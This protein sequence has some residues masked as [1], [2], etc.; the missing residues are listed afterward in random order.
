[1]TILSQSMTFLWHFCY[2][3]WRSVPCC[4]IF[5]V[6]RDI[7]WHFLDNLWHFCD[8]LWH[9]C[10]ILWHLKKC[11]PLFSAYWPSWG[12]AHWLE[13]YRTL[14]TCEPFS[15]DEKLKQKC[16]TAGCIT[17]TGRTLSKLFWGHVMSED[18]VIRIRAFK[19]WVSE[20]GMEKLQLMSKRVMPRDSAC[21]HYTQH[22]AGRWNHD[23]IFSGK[24]QNEIFYLRL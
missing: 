5:S 16:V 24:I 10:D 1:M 18:E 17:A 8:V 7:L 12:T 19:G 23:A 14:T 22:R 21:T 9:F 13:G 2:F 6:F 4:D 3:L 11:G 20:Y 15:N